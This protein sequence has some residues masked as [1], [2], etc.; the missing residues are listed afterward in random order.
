MVPDL[1]D[2]D[3][4]LG[5]NGWMSN[6]S[7]DRC[8]WCAG[9]AL[10]QDYH[11]KEWGVPSRENTALLEM[12]CL[13]GAQAGLSWITILNFAVMLVRQ[14]HYRKVVVPWLSLSGHMLM[15]NL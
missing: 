5:H 8:S 3:L 11:D 1:A 13:E 7:P 10:Y 12:L 2:P 14:S 9:S 4:D 6:P 15:I